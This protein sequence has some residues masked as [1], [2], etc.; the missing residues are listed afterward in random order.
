LHIVYVIA[1]GGGPEAYVKTLAPWLIKQGHQVSVIFTGGKPFDAQMPA[2]VK[3]WFAKSRQGHYYLGKLVGK[4]RLWAQRYR[5]METSLEVERIL[6]QV[7][8]EQPVHVVELTEGY[9]S[10]RI[11]R[12]FPVVVRAHGS[13]WA[14][15]HFCQDDDCRWDHILVREQA[16]QFRHAHVVSPL[17]RQY[18]CFLSTACNIPRNVFQ[19]LP[20]PVDLDRF[21]PDGDHLS[22]AADISLISIGRL[23]H[24]KGSDAA[25]QAMN[26]LWETFP[27]AHLYLLGNEAQ[28]TRSDLHSLAKETHRPKIVF[29]GFVLHE[30]V[31]TFLRSMKVYLALTQY[32]TFGYTILEA[33]ACGVPVVSCPVGAVPELVQD[34]VNGRL[35]PFGDV[36]LAAQAVLDLLRDDSLYRRMSRN[37]RK[38]ALAYSLQVIGPRHINMYT[39]ALDGFASR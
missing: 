14:F 3:T 35:V 38:T 15:R 30:Q 20:Y 22:D 12:R 25:V 28:F 31:P 11:S 9:D 23:E 2:G 32:E 39:Q 10:Q 7:H 33:M 13:V 5:T 18:A 1:P 27:D 16:G 17:S 36:T 24:R 26:M 21:S 4:F 8:R 6:F 29:P 37:A 34:G 19:E